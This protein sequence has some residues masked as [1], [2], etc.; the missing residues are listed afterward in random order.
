M[1]TNT[2][3][4]RPNVYK[5][6]AIQATIIANLGTACAACGHETVVGGSPA[7][8]WTFNLGHVH[9]DANGGAWT[10]DNLL[11]ICRRCNVAMGGTDWSESGAPMLVEPLSAS[12]PLLPDPG[13]EVWEPA[14]WQA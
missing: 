6:R 9:A 10:L 3:T 5:R 12:T 11:P 1:T 4:G 13:T 7:S 8:P 14:P 2:R